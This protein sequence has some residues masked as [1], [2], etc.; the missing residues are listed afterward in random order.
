M[1][2]ERRVQYKS[3]ERATYVVLRN[4]DLKPIAVHGF[5]L[6]HAKT[7]ADMYTRRTGNTT[8]VCKVVGM[9]LARD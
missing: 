2:K 5:T 7:K 1:A 4:K 3:S 6:A 9:A 8:L